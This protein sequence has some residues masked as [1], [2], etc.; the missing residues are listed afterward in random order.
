MRST[1]IHIPEPCAESWDAMTPTGSGRHCAA[2]QKTVIDFTLKSDAEILAIL[3]KSGSGSLCG[4]LR[5]EQLGRPLLAASSPKVLNRQW[6][7]WLATAISLWAWR[8]EALPR[9]LPASAQHYDSRLPKPPRRRTHSTVAPRRLHGTVRDAFTQK[10]LGGVAVFLKNENRSAVTDSAGHF[11]LPLPSKPQ[12]AHRS[13]ILHFA[14][15]YSRTLLVPPKATGT[16]EVLLQ[17]DPSAAGVEV[18][19][20]YVVHRS[21]N[22]GG[23]MVIVASSDVL[24]SAKTPK[25]WHQRA[26]Y[27]WLTHPFRR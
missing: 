20:K 7:T 17:A 19:V 2:C 12:A 10:P 13:L 16:L 24:T 15:Y 14:G 26:F 9:S 6:R 4:Q 8:A 25:P 22:T 1:T 27:R 3:A 11:S 18:I 21:F 23:S 5:A